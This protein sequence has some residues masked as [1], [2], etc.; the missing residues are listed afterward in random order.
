LQLLQVLG[1]AQ[2]LKPVATVAEYLK[3]VAADANTLSLL[4]VLQVF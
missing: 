1:D 3:P 4:Q 2:Y